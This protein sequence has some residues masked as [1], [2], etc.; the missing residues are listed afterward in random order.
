MNMQSAQLSRLEKLLV[1]DHRYLE[2]R[3][4]LPGNHSRL[5]Q[6]D[7]P[8]VLLKRLVE[9]N[10]LQEANRLFAYALPARE[11]VWWAC[12]C[13]EHTVCPSMAVPERHA[14]DAAQDWVRKPTV[15]AQ[16]HAGIL[17]RRAGYQYPSAWAAV[18]ASWVRKTEPTQQTTTEATSRVGQALENAVLLASL[19]GD[20]SRQPHRLLRFIDSGSDI[21]SGGAGRLR[22][23]FD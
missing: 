1:L 23:E 4:R 7:Q 8:R 17:A 2:L 12:M 21:A 13:V 6:E 16:R 5:L 20:P 22:P 3:L 15:E 10:L 9:R 19:R 11:A 14:L 18:A